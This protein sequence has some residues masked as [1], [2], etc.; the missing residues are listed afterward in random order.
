M[1]DEAM[2][3]SA[4]REAAKALYAQQLREQVEEKINRRHSEKQEQQTRNDKLSLS[5]ATHDVL[6]AESSTSA[7]KD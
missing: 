2:E 3:R 6:L 4:H 5:L 7:L 1:T